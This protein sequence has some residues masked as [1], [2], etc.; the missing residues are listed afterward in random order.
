MWP[1]AVRFPVRFN[2]LDHSIA[3]LL[4]RWTATRCAGYQQD[5]PQKREQAE[6]DFLFHPRT[7]RR[8]EAKFHIV[9]TASESLKRISTPF[10]LKN[11]QKKDSASY[12]PPSRC[13]NDLQDGC[14]DKSY[15]ET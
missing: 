9:Q 2:F 4:L 8:L 1:A 5:D 15:L 3:D 6:S 11:P 14:G 13:S 7:L 12:K 10:A